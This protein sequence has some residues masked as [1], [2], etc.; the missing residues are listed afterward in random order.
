MH[1]PHFVSLVW[2]LKS[3]SSLFLSLTAL[4][5]PLTLV[6][7]SPLDSPP[8]HLSVSLHLLIPFLLLLKM[9]EEK[10]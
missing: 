1:P 8:H 10:D 5:C 7:S 4:A 3:R 6:T 9:G 2:V